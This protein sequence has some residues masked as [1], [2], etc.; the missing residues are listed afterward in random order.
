MRLAR[1]TL[2]ILLCLPLIA[3]FEEPAR[4]SACQAPIPILQHPLYP[5]S[6]LLNPS[7]GG[8]TVTGQDEWPPLVNDVGMAVRRIRG[9]T[10]TAFVCP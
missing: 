9:P 1:A 5:K 8:R 2:I 3:C 7:D 4:A 10:V 6:E